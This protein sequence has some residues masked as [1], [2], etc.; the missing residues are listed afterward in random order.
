MF[1]GMIRKKGGNNPGGKKKRGPTSKNIIIIP[2]LEAI[3]W[4]TGEPIS[5]DTIK[6][7]KDKFFQKLKKR[8]EAR[9]EREE[10]KRYK[11]MVESYQL[12]KEEREEREEEGREEA[13]AEDDDLMDTRHIDSEPE[14]GDDERSSKKEELYRY[15]FLMNGGASVL[16]EEE[17]E[18]LRH[19]INRITRSG[20]RRVSLSD[21]LDTIDSWLAS[22]PTSYVKSRRSKRGKNKLKTRPTTQGY[23]VHV[24][25]GGD[26]EEVRMTMSMIVPKIPKGDTQIKTLV[27]TIARLVKKYSI[28]GVGK[29]EM[30]PNLRFLTRAPKQGGSICTTMW[31]WKP[32]ARDHPRLMSGAGHDVRARRAAETF[33]RSIQC[34]K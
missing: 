15:N 17:E 2:W 34:R 23:T 30:I 26:D 1:E 3:P 22:R 27:R 24:E 25:E 12:A 13:Q 32:V 7:L 4:P 11:E 9:R 28:S 18:R 21:D 20:V 8:E 10:A 14:D 33:F 29:I 31:V 5:L 16:P 6:V 19:S